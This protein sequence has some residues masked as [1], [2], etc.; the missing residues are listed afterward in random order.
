MIWV[1]GGGCYVSVYVGLVVG[2]VGS[3]GGWCIAGGVIVVDERVVSVYGGIV[4]DN[5]VG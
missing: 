2:Y 3:G 5:C 4:G 1:G